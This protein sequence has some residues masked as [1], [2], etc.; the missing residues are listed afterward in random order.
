VKLAVD[1]RL[2]DLDETRRALWLERAPADAREVREATAA[3][4][5]RVRHEGDD[6]LLDLARRFDGVALDALEVPRA[7]WDEARDGLA[8]DVRAALE[9]AARNIDTFHR[10]QIPGELVVEVEPGVVLGRRFVPLDV[11]GVYAPG[12]QAAYPS[13]VLMGAVPARAAGVREI[14]VCSPPAADGL[15][16][17]VVCAAAAVAGVTR[18][19][20]VGG[21]GAI[22]A[23]A[24]GTRSVP[25][26]GLVVGPGNRWVTEAKRQVAGDVRIDAPAG[27][28]EVLV[29]AEGPADPAR[30]AAEL[31]AQAEHDPDAVVVLVTPSAGLL[32]GVRAALARQV[33]TAPRR[34]T[35]EAALATRGALLLADDLDQALEFAHAFAPEHLSLHTTDPARDLDRVSTAGTVFLGEGS[36]VA[37]GDYVTGANHVLPTAGAA[38]AFSGL[39]TLDFLRSFTWQRIDAAAGA[40][41]A[42]VVEALAAAEGLPAHAAAA[43]LRQ[44]ATSDLGGLAT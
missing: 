18:L 5:E 16:S 13:S 19:F 14:V 15:P 21:A 26:C 3:I 24:Y 8:P 9:R 29:V 6:A 20:A 17:P 43:R 23:L 32:D 28:S 30:I 33:A 1:G 37:F 41:L 42:P 34:A 36:S 12:G 39:S 38:R 27:P 22:A 4:V 7:A 10:A 11:V 31:V 2:A 40:R 44:G 25:R 35:V